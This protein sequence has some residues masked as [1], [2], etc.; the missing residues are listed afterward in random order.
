MIKIGIDPSAR[1]YG[2]AVAT[3][4]YEELQFHHF[5]NH[6]LDFQK[7]IDTFKQLQIKACIENSHLQNT[8]FKY[9]KSLGKVKRYSRNVGMNQYCSLLTV[10]YLQLEG[11]EVIQ[12][13]PK[14]KGRKWGKKFGTAMIEAFLLNKKYK[15]N[16]SLS[17]LTEDEIDAFKMLTFIL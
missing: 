7:Y 8:T 12:V 1:K 9:D 16:K 2:F 6:F 4:Y 13:S 15:V 14:K 3:L 5:K 17:K 10:L 11:I